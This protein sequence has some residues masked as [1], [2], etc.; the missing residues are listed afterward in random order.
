MF[1]NTIIFIRALEV[2][3][4]TVASWLGKFSARLCK[5]C[6]L[7]EVMIWNEIFA[8][9]TTTHERFLRFRSKI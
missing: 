1:L 5:Q 2:G 9:P 7:P 6:R 4:L 8:A 3:I